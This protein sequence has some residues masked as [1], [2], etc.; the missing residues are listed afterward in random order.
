MAQNQRTTK[1][2]N[3]DELF[4]RQNTSINNQLNLQF[5]QN[6]DPF[7]IQDLKILSIFPPVAPHQT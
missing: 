6:G 1:F 2:I 3:W 7:Q 5:F 4:S